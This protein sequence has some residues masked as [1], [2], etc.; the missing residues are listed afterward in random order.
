MATRGPPLEAAATAMS[1]VASPSRS[2][3]ATLTPPRNDCSNGMNRND[4]RLVFGSMTITNGSDPALAPMTRALLG[5]T[6][7]TVRHS[8]VPIW[9]W[10]R[11]ERR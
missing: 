10:K 7:G 3:T 5:T 11:N 1:G 2:P 8:S 4:S 6:L 9:G